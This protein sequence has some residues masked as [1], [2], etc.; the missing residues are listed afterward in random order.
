MAFSEFL[1]QGGAYK[2]TV[3]QYMQGTDVQGTVFINGD[4]IHADY[5]IAVQGMT[6]DSSMTVRDGYS[7]TW[8]SMMPGTGYKSKVVTSSD[9]SVGGTDTSGTYAWNAEQIGDYN[10]EA[11]NHDEETF[12][13]PTGVTFT[14][15]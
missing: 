11:W 5:N 10:C 4:K 1:K 9:T 13:L 12:A 15:M 14:E 7:Y 6:I 3:N 8:S 2:C